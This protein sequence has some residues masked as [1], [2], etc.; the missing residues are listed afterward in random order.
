MT[1]TRTVTFTQMKDGTREDYLLLEEK[2]KPFLAL[3]ADR[4]LGELRRAGEVTL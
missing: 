4:V 2:E 1:D 3:T